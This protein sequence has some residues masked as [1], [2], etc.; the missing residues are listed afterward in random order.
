MPQ[1]VGAECRG[2][3][4]G[5]TVAIVSVAAVGCGG[6]VVAPVAR[7]RVVAE[8]VEVEMVMGP[9]SAARGANPA[10]ATGLALVAGVS[11]DARLLVITADGESASLAAISSALDYLGT[12]YDVFN[13]GSGPDLT[14]D[15][16]ADG[17]HGRYYGIVL[18]TGDLAIGSTSALSDAEWMTL[19]SYE[20]RFGARRAV[21]Y[22]RPSESYGLVHDAR[23]RRQSGTDSRALHD[24]GQQRVRGRELRRYRRDRGRLGVRRPALRRGHG[25]VARR[26]GGQRLRGNPNATRTAVR[27]WC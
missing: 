11:V 14:A 27:C 21:M 25:A 23:L 15:R 8:P 4:W 2:W 22:A 20:A 7:D 3:F 12:P 16:L 18:D 26:R 10:P 5:V 19:A 24:R 9:L 1:R 6:D 13:A 17:D